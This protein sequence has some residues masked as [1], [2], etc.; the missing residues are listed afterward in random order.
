[1]ENTFPTMHQATRG[2]VTP[3]VSTKDVLPP[4]NSPSFLVCK[5]TNGA[6]DVE[7]QWHKM[8]G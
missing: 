2:D 1:M 5:T 4:V 8:K 6:I 3:L 7:A